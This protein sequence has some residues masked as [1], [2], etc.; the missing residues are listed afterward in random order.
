MPASFPSTI[1]T[2]SKQYLKTVRIEGI[3]IQLY[4]RGSGEPLLLLHG[5]FGDCFDWEPV[6]EP[7]SRGYRVNAVDLPG[8]GGSGK[9]DVECTGEFFVRHIDALLH[10]L[11]VNK[12]TIVG[13]S[14]GGIL[15]RK[16]VV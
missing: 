12:V 3:D 14:L 2:S 13:N 11:G 15:D 6:L 4:D 9:P 8:F 5:M 10:Q 16:S 7:L 1:D